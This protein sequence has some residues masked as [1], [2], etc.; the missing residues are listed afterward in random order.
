[1]KISKQGIWK[2]DFRGKESEEIVTK[3]KDYFAESVSE[4]K[5][6][7]VILDKDKDKD[8]KSLFSKLFGKNK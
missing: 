7:S 5:K 6:D 3:L 8:K 2:F 4:L 1:M